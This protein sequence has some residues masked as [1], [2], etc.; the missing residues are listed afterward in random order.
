MLQG[1]NLRVCL[2]KSHPHTLINHPRESNNMSILDILMF[3][4]F[5]FIYFIYSDYYAIP[6]F[7][8]NKIKA[9]LANSNHLIQ[10][11]LRLNG[12]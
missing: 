12:C 9:L 3:S 4:F 2:Y 5:L 11:K 6:K 8:Q 7:F 1:F 10:L